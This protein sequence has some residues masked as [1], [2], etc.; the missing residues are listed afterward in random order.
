MASRY[1]TVGIGLAAIVALAACSGDKKEP[2]GDPEESLAQDGADTSTAEIDAEIVTSTLISATASGGSLTLASA[3]ELG[4]GALGPADVGD[5]AKVFFFP[6]G[7][8]DVAHDAAAQTVTYRFNDCAGPNGLFRVRGEIEA[9]YSTAP[10]KLILNLD[11]NALTLN[12]ATLDWSATAEITAAGAAREMRWKGQ[13]SGSTARGHALSRTNEKVV[14]WRFGEPCFAVSGVSQ[15]E[16]RGRSLQ[17]EITDFRR[18]RRGCPEA[19]GKI[20]ITNAQS[21]AKVEITFDGTNRATYTSA[22]G[23]V[24]FPLLCRD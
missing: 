13:L 7:C 12:N 9:R 22:R 20:A 5:G 24:Q 10:G 16:V 8:L 4:G 23:S 2:D 19:G 1:S 6:K 3:P 18:C 21:G 17:T 14:S 15:G 11:G